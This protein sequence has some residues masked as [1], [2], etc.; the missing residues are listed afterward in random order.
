MCA[1]LCGADGAS[2]SGAGTVLPLAADRVLRGDRRRA[3]DRVAGGGFA[4]AA[5]FSWGGAERD[6]TGSLD[7][8]A[9]AAADRCR[10]ASSGV[11]VGAGVVGG[12]GPAE[13]EDRGHR[14]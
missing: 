4:G 14:Y 5:Q 7:D 1:L 3:G 10:D 8:F 12:E 9:Y 2:K 13:G 11:P 6:A